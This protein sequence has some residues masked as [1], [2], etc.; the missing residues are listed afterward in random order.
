MD[1]QPR[2]IDL[3]SQISDSNPFKKRVAAA[4]D[5]PDFLKKDMEAIGLDKRL[6]EMGKKEKKQGYLRKTIRELRDLQKPIEEYHAETETMR[7]TAKLPKFDPA[8]VVGFLRRQEL[9]VASRAMT[10]GQRSM[11]MTGPHRS[12]NFLDAVLEYADDPWISGVNVY[13]PGELTVYEAAKQ[14]RLRDF[15]APLLDTIADREGVE[16]EA[17]TVVNV[18]RDDIATD[19]GLKRDEFE[20]FA[21]PIEAKQNAP[22]LH[23]YTEEGKEVIRVIDVETHRAAIATEDQIRDGKYYR[24][25]AE[26]LADRSAA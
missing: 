17:M 26:Y 22:W 20:A 25:Q 12:L 15:H 3:L 4:F 2:N 10:F 13:D 9:R 19:S 5:L 18:A 24:D 6:S 7:A 8:D 14:E 16:R 1:R 23:R 21:T 11:H